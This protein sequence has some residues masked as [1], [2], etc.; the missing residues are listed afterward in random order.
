LEEPTPVGW[1]RAR[2]LGRSW[3]D[4]AEG[5]YDRVFAPQDTHGQAWVAVAGSRWTV[6]TS[7]EEAKGEVGRDP[8]EVRSWEGGYRPITRVMAALAAVH[9]RLQADG[10]P[11]KRPLLRTCSWP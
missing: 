5:A 6:E 4:A 9:A 1:Q 8:Y 11:K 3:K 10:T 2:L 7:F